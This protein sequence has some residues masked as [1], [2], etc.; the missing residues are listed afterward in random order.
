VLIRAFSSQPE[1]SI[2]LPNIPATRATIFPRENNRHFYIH[3][4][5]ATSKSG[6]DANA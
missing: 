1:L 2:Y 4:S 5:W 6:G 3:I